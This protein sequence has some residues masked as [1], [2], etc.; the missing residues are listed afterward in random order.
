MISLQQLEEAI[1]RARSSHPATGTDACLHPDVAVL[2]GIYGEMIFRR[3][4]LLNP[5]L[6]GESQ[7]EV[8]ARWCRSMA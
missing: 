3:L 6:L 2:G 8:L 5:A 7:R 4:K 1:N